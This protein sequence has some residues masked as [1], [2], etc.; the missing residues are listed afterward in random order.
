MLEL[1]LLFKCSFLVPNLELQLLFKCSVLAPNLELQLLFKRSC[2]APNLFGF[3][4]WLGE[5]RVWLRGAS[6][7]VLEGRVWLRGASCRGVVGRCH[8]QMEW[9]GFKF[10]VLRV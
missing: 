3:S 8:K 7:R 9:A 5:R 1:Q 2:L 4:V 6:G 10:K